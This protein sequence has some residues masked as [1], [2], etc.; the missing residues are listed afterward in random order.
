MADTVE[1]LTTGEPLSIDQLIEY[2][3]ALKEVARAQLENW[4]KGAAVLH[5]FRKGEIVC[6][7]GEFGSTA[8]YIVSGNV[9]IFINNPLAHLRTRPQSG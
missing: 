7:E 9:D 6:R 5:R 4:A 2:L 1:K 3:P 8:Y